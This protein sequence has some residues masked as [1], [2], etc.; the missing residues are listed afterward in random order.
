MGP[1]MQTQKLVDVFALSGQRIGRYT[2]EVAGYGNERMAERRAIDEAIKN[3]DVGES[4]R[5]R[6][7]AVVRKS[8]PQQWR[9]AA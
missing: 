6:L 5:P 3:G 2:V 8:A 4:D 7:V 1:E 9:R